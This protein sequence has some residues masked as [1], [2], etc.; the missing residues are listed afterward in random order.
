[1]ENTR[2]VGSFMGQVVQHG[3]EWRAEI[4]FDPPARAPILGEP[5]KTREAAALDL[6]RLAK[7][8]EAVFLSAGFG[9]AEVSL[10]KTCFCHG[11]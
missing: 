2:M 4:S 5:Y 10:V 7:Y 9:V 1:M 3:N 11:N 8:W 6:R